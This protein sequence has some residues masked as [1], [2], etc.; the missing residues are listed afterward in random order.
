MYVDP[1]GRKI[2]RVPKHSI[3]S[4]SL[5]HYLK[6]YSIVRCI[7]GVLMPEI[8]IDQPLQAKPRQLFV[9]QS[10]VLAGKVEEYFSNPW[11]PH[12][13]H[14]EKFLIL[15]R[16]NKRSI[17][18]GASSILTMTIIDAAISLHG[19]ANWK[20]TIFFFSSLLT[21]VCVSVPKM[22]P[23]HANTYILSAG[24]L[25]KCGQTKVW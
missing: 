22:T 6:R 9:T 23:R 11:P 12:H 20:I 16:R 25:S 24:V 10:R 19:L 21:G 1:T 7:L 4:K 3:G 2:A 8:R 17:K 18:T 15:Q 13:I 5:F 14:P